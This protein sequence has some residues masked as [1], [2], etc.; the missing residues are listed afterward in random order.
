MDFSVIELDAEHRKLQSDARAFAEQYLTEEVRQHEF[1]T[2]DGWNE[3][4]HLA[5]AER[6]WVL[7]DLP[8]ERGG[9]GM[10]ALGRRILEL[11]LMKAELP[12]ATLDTTRW[13]ATAVEQ[14]APDAIRDEVIA[15]TAA[16]RYRHCLGYTEP[17]GGSDIAGAKTRAV[18]D[19]D[20]WV[21]NGSKM[22]TTGAHNCQYTFLITRTDPQAPKHRGLTMFL[23]PLDSN[24]IEIQGIRA[25]SGER[26]NI[27]YYDDVRVSDDYR[28]GEVNQ[29]WT[30][31]RGA[32]DTEHGI[33]QEAVGLE[34]A[35]V[36][37]KVAHQLYLALKAAAR[38]AATPGA[39]GIR[40][41]DDGLVCY[42]LGSVALQLEAALHTP[43]AAGKVKCAETMVQ[44]AAELLDL[45]GPAGLLSRGSPGAIGNGRV[46]FT[47]RYAQGAATYGGTVEVFR[48]IIAEFDLGL[49][50]TKLPGSKTFLPHSAS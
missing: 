2:G 37:V 3:K 18:R 17:D 24:G 36:G 19:G 4:V 32:L 50:R 45:L 13:V 27:V 8:V 42:R 33:G 40:P 44:G 26:T 46:E 28:I 35:S 20:D 23:V 16:G 21:I 6:G 47:H 10:D 14:Y 12:W 49:P 11:E 39:G 29:G 22:F 34:D 15:G 1:A 41:G 5:M 25:F 7:P 30:V 43:N 38:W 48:N 31:L 9:V